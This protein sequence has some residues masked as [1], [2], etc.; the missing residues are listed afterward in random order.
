MFLTIYLFFSLISA[1]HA[2]EPSCTSCKFFIPHKSN[3]ELGL[4]KMFQDRV[5]N[6]K[7]VKNLAIHCRNNE[8]LCGKEGFLYE[9]NDDLN[10]TIERYEN[11]EKMC[12]GE[13]TEMHDLKELEELEKEMLE[14]FQKMRKHNKK[15]VYKTA[16][17][18]YKIIK[19]KNKK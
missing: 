17:D 18:I 12:Y 8:D 9:L 11:V 19:N 3:I 5:Y 15:R 16:N 1:I 13:L 4:C 7:L 14:I 6:D 2:F 10:N